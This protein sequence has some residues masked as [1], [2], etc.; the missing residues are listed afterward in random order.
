MVF[1]GF[2]LNKVGVLHL[3]PEWEP[4]PA[5]LPV[6]EIINIV[7]SVLSSHDVG[8]IRAIKT[9]KETWD[10]RSRDIRHQ[11]DVGVVTGSSLNNPFKEMWEPSG[12]S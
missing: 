9:N 1:T 10:S 11:R 2:K 3:K 8:K 6:I 7:A 4:R 5:T 12:R